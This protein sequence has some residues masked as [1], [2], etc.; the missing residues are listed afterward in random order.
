VKEASNEWPVLAERCFHALDHDRVRFRD[1]T[2]KCAVAVA[3]AVAVGVGV[4]L[5]AALELAVEAVVVVGSVAA[6]AA[7]L[8]EIEAAESKR[9]MC[10]C[11]CA[12]KGF[13]FGDGSVK[14][15][16]LAACHSYCAITYAGTT[17]V[18]R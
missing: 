18:C 8:A 16:D 5:L 9:K 11:L 14:V 17:G 13:L 3:P 10:T 1:V 12:K 7:I 15:K 2:G 4:C 6:A